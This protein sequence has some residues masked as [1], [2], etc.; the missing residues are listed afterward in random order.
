MYQQPLTYFPT[1]WTAH[2]TLHQHILDQVDANPKS[3]VVRKIERLQFLVTL[4]ASYGGFNHIKKVFYKR[5]QT[6]NLMQVI[7]VHQ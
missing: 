3:A 5:N 7:T 2:K 6:T 1:C 4:G